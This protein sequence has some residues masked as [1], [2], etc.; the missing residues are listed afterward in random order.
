M[1][2]LGCPGRTTPTNA[3]ALSGRTPSRDNPFQPNV[4]ESHSPID[5]SPPAIHSTASSLSPRWSAT[6]RDSSSSGG[7]NGSCPTSARAS[8][9]SPCHRRYRRG[10][11]ADPCRSRRVDRT[12]AGHSRSPSRLRQA[13]RGPPRRLAPALGRQQP[14]TTRATAPDRRADEASAA[15]WPLASRHANHHHWACRPSRR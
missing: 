5:S 4:A 8:T 2:T 11:S 9:R 15:L 3:P 14:R 13:V 6:I 7:L 1:E 12:A 10:L